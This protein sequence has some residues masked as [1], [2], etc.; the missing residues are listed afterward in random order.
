MSRKSWVKRQPAAPRGLSRRAS[1]ALGRVQQL[2]DAGDLEEAAT[3]L[4]NRLK[5][6]PNETDSLGMLTMVYASMGHSQRA[7]QLNERRRKLDSHNEQVWQFAIQLALG[8]HLIFT[9]R[10]HIEHYLQ[11]FPYGLSRSRIEQLQPD[12]EKAC[13]AITATDAVAAS[14]DPADLVLFERA[15]MLVESGE[16]LE[17]RKLALRVAE[18]LPHFVAPQ[19]HVVLSYVIEGK[20]D[21]ALQAAQQVLERFPGNIHALANTVQVL[22]RTGRKDEARQVAEQLKQPETTAN[23]DLWLKRLEAFT[24]LGDDALVCHIYEAES[25]DPAPPFALHLAAVAYARTGHPKKARDLWNKVLQV[26]PDDEL[27]LENLEDLKLPVGEQNG[28]RPFPF[29]QWLTPDWHRAM[30]AVARLRNP[31][32]MEREM[33][34]VIEST[35]GLIV[36]LQILL[37]RGD[38]FGRELA[39]QTAVQLELP[40]L[41]DFALSSYGTH[42]QR[43]AAL[44]AA[45]KA[46]LLPR[47]QSM[48][49][50][51]KGKQNVCTGRQNRGGQCPA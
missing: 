43:M 24:Y 18:K 50:F 27:A 33:R 47:G 15:R 42:E 40:M 10:A 41:K 16:Y 6:K 38:P 8:N 36:M 34:K 26:H 14:A 1:T 5:N 2:I 30:T 3:I 31:D 51:I 19:N 7:W 37:E 44:N 32:A 4:E 11:V 17:G 28:A 9:A 22:V 13:E 39:L 45:T 23:P 25:H 21:E 29:Q 35:P 12:I 46:H 20:F 48:P 49:M